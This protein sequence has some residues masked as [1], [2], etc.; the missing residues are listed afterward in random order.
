MGSIKSTKRQ[1]I[2]QMYDYHCAYCGREIT[3]ENGTIDHKQPQI[4]GGTNK[5]ENLLPC[6]GMCNG[7]KSDRSVEEY[8]N[9]V[10]IRI[11]EL[12]YFGLRPES[13]T[14]YFEKYYERKD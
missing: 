7:I 11:N 13:I 6:C 12:F 9:Y 3:D 8:R 5:Y 4:Y 2:L 1:N 10:A 14:F